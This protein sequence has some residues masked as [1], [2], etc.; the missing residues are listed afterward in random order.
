VSRER[1][2]IVALAA[3]AGVALLT[4]RGS[5]GVAPTAFGLGALAGV[6][7]LLAG[8]AR[9]ESQGRV[10]AAATVLGL[11]ALGLVAAQDHYRPGVSMGHDITYHTWSIW[12]LWRC[13][14]DGDLFPRW[15][16]Y[17]GLGVPLLQFY[18]PLA[19]LPAWPAQALGASPVQALA[20]LMALGQIGC[21]LTTYASMRWCGGSR[22]AGLVAATA[23]VLAPYHLVDQTFRVAVAEH[24][25][26]VFFAPS[27]VAAWK[28]AG[29]EKGRAPWVLGLCLA[30][31]LLTHILSIITATVL[32]VGPVG[33][34]LRRV[35]GRPAVRTLVVT[36]LVTVAATAAWWMPL[37]VEVRHTSVTRIAPVVSGVGVDGLAPWEGF[38]R[39]AWERYGIRRAAGAGQ[40]QGMPIYLGLT[41]IALVVLAWRRPPVEV[42]ASPRTGPDPRWWAVLAGL[43]FVLA[44]RPFAYLLDIVPGYGLVQYP[45][46]LLAPAAVFAGMAG[47]AAVDAWGSDRRGL[48]AAVALAVLA[49]DASMY[50]GAG[51]RWGDH[52]GLGLVALRGTEVIDLDAPLEPGVF[53]R[54]EQARVP[55]SDYEAR[56]AL[57]RRAYP[58]YMTPP[59]RERYAK[60]WDRPPTRAVSEA[61]HVTWRLKWRTDRADRLDP[62]PYTSWDDGSGWSPDPE[63]TWSRVP[64][65]IV[66]QL[67]EGRGEGAVRIAEM[68]FPGWLAR[69]DDGPWIEATSADELLAADVPA[70]ARRVEFLYSALRPWDRA[71]GLLLST[72]TLLGLG[73]AALR[74][75]G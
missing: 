13:V 43:G 33:W 20:W 63:A 28:V 64:E 66:V 31:L 32:L 10:A 73:G 70:G 42:D 72:G 46:R 69:V 23:A 35:G 49:A 53:V 39:A 34:R 45:W 8:L 48:L 11:V 44:T 52:D 60:G 75:R 19:Y 5:M 22:A 36:G 56:V 25:A 15:N 3:A 29:G 17:L 4:T 62:A 30:G 14:L 27:A 9:V 51:A 47:G 61:L 57:A 71:L 55:P 1:T 65:R 7:L 41:W 67:P 16:P 38:V 6:V 26:F 40:A 37:V 58:E 18:P 2:W 12:S 24:M 50:L 54:V 21:A 59:L 68:A 74:R